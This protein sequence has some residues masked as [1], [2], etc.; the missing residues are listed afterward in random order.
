MKRFLSSRGFLYV[1]FFLSSIHAKSQDFS[2]VATVNKNAISTTENLQLT[3][4]ITNASGKIALP[5]LKDWQVVGGPQTR[6]EMNMMNGKMS[7]AYSETYF[8]KPLKEGFMIIPEI[9]VQTD[10]GKLAT[11]PITVTV[12]KGA[13]I[14]S[15]QQGSQPQQTPSSSGD[16]WVEVQLSKRKVYVGEPVLATYVF[17]S[18]YDP[19]HLEEVK[20]PK[21]DGFW[22]EEISNDI[23]VETTVINGKR[24]AT[25]VVRR[26]LLFPQVSG[27]LD[28]DG[29][30]LTLLASKGGSFFFRENT[31][32]KDS[33]PKITVEVMPYPAKQPANFHGTYS[34]LSLSAKADRTE[35]K[36]NEAINLTVTINGK[37]NL[38]L[39]EELPYEF[40]TDFETFEPKVNDNITV[41]AGG[42]SGSRTFEYVLIPR[43][44]GDYT[45]AP[46]SI[47]YF[48]YETKSFKSLS[49][50][51]LNFKVTPGDANNAGNYTYDSRSDVQ[52]LSQDIRHIK[53]QPVVLAG[54]GNL[55]F[56][57]VG[58]Y[59]L[60]VLP[61]LLFAAFVVVRKRQDAEEADE[62]GTGK[63]KAGKL[64]RQHLQ[65]AS[66]MLKQRNSEGFYSELSQAIHG[67][68]AKK[69]ALPPSELNKQR[70]ATELENSAGNTLSEQVLSL[71]NECEVARFSKSSSFLSPQQ[72][73]EKAHIVI[74]SLEKLIKQEGS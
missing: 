18:A 59:G 49:T 38:K 2:F 36:A 10:K 55:F 63:R 28:I 54:K 31:R 34:P 17:Y 20:Y 45:I 15:A 46:L 7:S 4:R 19:Q 66:G 12:T 14:P 39:L 57:S 47:S 1:L 32:L 27:N 9:T 21:H 60:M 25:A 74:E 33:A 5:Q 35:L 29:F 50:E 71:L 53:T 11:R 68:L 51:A 37:G 26:E 40:P 8:L 24:Y 3:L 62:T 30:A 41:N 13:A 58:F 65:A 70:I 72:L 52:L 43:T 73:L 6:N 48:D 69:F 23:K 67:Y 42:E 44:A 64:S 56:G 22:S 61:A 16:F